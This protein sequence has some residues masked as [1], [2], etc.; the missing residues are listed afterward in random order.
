MNIVDCRPASHFEQSLDRGDNCGSRYTGGEESAVAN[1]GR[2]SMRVLALR[3]ESMSKGCITLCYLPGAAFHAHAMVL[4]L[5]P[6]EGL[7]LIF[8]NRQRYHS[9]DQKRG[10]EGGERGVHDQ[11]NMPKRFVWWMRV[12]G[13]SR[14]LDKR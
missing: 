9:R 4:A 12:Y 7:D 2:I 14:E 10:H 5:D 1:F 11:S 8:G 3:W 6:S 13:S